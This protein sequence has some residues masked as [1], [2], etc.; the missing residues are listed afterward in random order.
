M[1]NVTDAGAYSPANSPFGTFDQAGNV[2]EYLEDLTFLAMN[3]LA[4]TAVETIAS[5]AG[6]TAAFASAAVGAGLCVALSLVPYTLVVAGMAQLRPA[7]WPGSERAR[8]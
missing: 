1:G 8:E 4:P 7:A 6:W 3:A 2:A 5:R